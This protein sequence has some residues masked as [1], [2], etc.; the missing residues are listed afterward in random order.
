VAEPFGAAHARK[1]A[2]LTDT[3]DICAAELL[4]FRWK[5]AA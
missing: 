2:P 5:P 3:L 1:R 4:P